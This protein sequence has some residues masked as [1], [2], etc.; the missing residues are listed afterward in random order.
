MRVARPSALRHALT[1]LAAAGALPSGLAAQ[2]PRPVA[3][4]AEVR[5][6]APPV[7]GWR[8]GRLVAF[9]STRL[10]L[11]DARRERAG[12]PNDTILR[13]A[14]QRFEL[15]RRP[16]RVTRA[17]GYG[18]LGALT[19]AV[20]VGFIGY[21][22]TRCTACEDDGIGVLLAPPAF[23]VGGLVGAVVGATSKGRWVPV[24]LPDAAP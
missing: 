14:V 18:A 17:V 3:L 22:T 12:S 16:D 13:G 24:P 9:D 19:S 10:V 1:T 11:G 23:L 15:Y 21:H 8:E 20:V 5:V 2:A 7:P 4:G 6:V